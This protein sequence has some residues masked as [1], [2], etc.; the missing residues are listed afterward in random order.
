MLFSVP[1]ASFFSLPQV[2]FGNPKGNETLRSNF[3]RG[4]VATLKSFLAALPKIPTRKQL[5]R[6]VIQESFAIVT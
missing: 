5:L 1:I 3:K 2:D 6:K 4:W